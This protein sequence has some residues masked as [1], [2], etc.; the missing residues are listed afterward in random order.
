MLPT[1]KVPETGQAGDRLL[2][3][4]LPRFAPQQ[5][6]ENAFLALTTSGQAVNSL[7]QPIKVRRV[8]LSQSRDFLSQRAEADHQILQA[9]N[10]FFM[11]IGR[12]S[13]GHGLQTRVGV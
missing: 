12:L 1:N 5:V 3:V 2:G 6:I 13:A 10:A 7:S 11:V 4:N 9:A 8:S